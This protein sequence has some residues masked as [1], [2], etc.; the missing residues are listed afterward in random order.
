MIDPDDQDAT[1]PFR[2][3]GASDS[4]TLCLAEGQLHVSI[5]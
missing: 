5:A 3:E 1:A 4:P 2:V